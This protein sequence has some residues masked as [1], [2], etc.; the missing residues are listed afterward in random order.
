MRPNPSGG[1]GR[2]LDEFCERGTSRAGVH[3]QTKAGYLPDHHLRWRLV[4]L[5]GCHFGLQMRREQGHEDR[6]DLAT[7]TMTLPGGLH[8]ISWS[9]FTKRG[10]QCIDVAV[11][12]RKT[13][14]RATLRSE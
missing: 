5:H 6:Q 8:Q 12:S 13:R 4:V 10:E 11:P 9:N 1:L 7:P 14:R 2:S 3:V